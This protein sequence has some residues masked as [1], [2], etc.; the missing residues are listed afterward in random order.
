MCAFPYSHGP[1]SA[2]RLAALSELPP[3][4]AWP[5]PIPW[6]PCHCPTLM[7]FILT[8]PHP[9]PHGFLIL[10]SA[11]W[12]QLMPSG[13]SYCPNEHTR[14]HA[15][16]IRHGA[17]RGENGKGLML[18]SQNLNSRF[19]HQEAI[20][21][22][23]VTLQKILSTRLEAA[24]LCVCNLFLKVFFSGTIPISLLIPSK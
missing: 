22:Y 4:T 21:N 17:H 5:H 18:S 7:S 12:P 8:L 16:A 20:F 19:T 11:N 23:N 2:W 3:T 10:S 6:G 14:I 15:M 24:H 1:V 13:T 9:D